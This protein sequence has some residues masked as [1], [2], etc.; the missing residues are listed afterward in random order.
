MTRRREYHW[1]REDPRRP[2]VRDTYN[3][4]LANQEGEEGWGVEE[5]QEEDEVIVWGE[6]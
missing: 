4:R 6:R 3:T 5:K 1:V 2:G